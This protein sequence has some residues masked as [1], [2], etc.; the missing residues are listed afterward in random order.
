LQQFGAGFL[1]PVF[2]LFGRE[3]VGFTQAEIGR[4]LLFPALT[5]ALFAI[6]L[7]RIADVIGKSRAVR[8]VF[9]AAALAI[10]LMPG[11]K[12]PLLWQFLIAVLGLAYVTG[13]PAWTALASMAAPPGRQGAAI[14]A[15]GT[16]QSL[17][18]ILGPGVGGF[19]YDRV[20]PAAPFYGC[21]L[22]LVVCF[23]LASLLVS[24][25]RINKRWHDR[26]LF[27]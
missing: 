22:F 26:H 2:V 1:A 7:G 24:E 10:F 8:C 20:A 21:A 11:A 13:A 12:H 27:G 6:P 3:Q 23:V 17:G 9:L 19:L 16:M 18:F 14:A 4:I 5:I 15:I 25:K